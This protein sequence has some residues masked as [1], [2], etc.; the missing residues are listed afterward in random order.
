[1]QTCRLL[2]RGVA[3]PASAA[4]CVAPEY[5]VS[6]VLSLPSAPTGMTRWGRG[7]FCRLTF[8]SL[9]CA[10]AISEPHSV[11][12]IGRRLVLEGRRRVHLAPA[13]DT[14]RMSGATLTAADLRRSSLVG[15]HVGLHHARV[16]RDL[17]L[18]QA[19]QPHQTLVLEGVELPRRGVQHPAG[20][21]RGELLVLLAVVDALAALGGLDEVL[22]GTPVGHAVHE[23]SAQ[24]RVL[25]EVA[26]EPGLRVLE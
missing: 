3:C 6:R 12:V 20:A 7:R 5:R 4:C 2:L 19:L 24:R 13:A 15:E 10:C 1:V 14:Y 17:A 23:R 16:H 25:L 18:T 9:R 26:D 21:R 22:E 11:V 8:S